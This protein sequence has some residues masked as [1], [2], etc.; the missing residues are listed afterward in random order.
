MKTRILIE[1]T[2][3]EG[4]KDELDKHAGA[5]L[6]RSEIVEVGD[7]MSP[8]YLWSAIRDHICGCPFNFLAEV[9]SYC[10]EDKTP[11]DNRAD[12]PTLRRFCDVAC[13][14]INYREKE[15]P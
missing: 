2:V 7:S 11:N 10:W 12:A 6:H 4:D 14:V 5:I 8:A 15:K 9:V 1:T 3:D 13:A